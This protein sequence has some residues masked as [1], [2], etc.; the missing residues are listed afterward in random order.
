MKKCAAFK[1]FR[2]IGDAKAFYDIGNFVPY[3]IKNFREDAR[4]CEEEVCRKR[5]HSA[6]EC[7][8]AHSLFWESF[9]EG[10]E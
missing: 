4:P 7:A 6:Q 9:L 3:I 8:L 5:P 10:E 1:P 2:L